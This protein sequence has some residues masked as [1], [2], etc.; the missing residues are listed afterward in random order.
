MLQRVIHK[1]HTISNTYI[2]LKA[3]FYSQKQCFYPK[4]YLRIVNHRLSTYLINYLCSKALH[5]FAVKGRFI[6]LM[7]N[8]FN[9]NSDRVLNNKPYY[10]FIYLILIK[11]LALNQAFKRIIFS[12]CLLFHEF[13]FILLASHIAFHICAKIIF[14]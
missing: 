8:R 14:Y 5:V 10:L 11:F 6:R 12:A 3:L 13:Q 1:F 2:F 9:S 7:A 4:I